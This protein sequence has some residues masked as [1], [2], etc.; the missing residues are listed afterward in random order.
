MRGVEVRRSKLVLG[1]RGSGSVGKG[2]PREENASPGRLRGS[3]G[4]RCRCRG[5]ISVHPGADVHPGPG[6]GA[7]DCCCLQGLGTKWHHLN[8]NPFS[9]RWTA[10]PDKEH[11]SR[12][13]QVTVIK[14]SNICSTSPYTDPDPE[15]RIFRFPWTTDR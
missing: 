13:M 3:T 15:I 2:V 11:F 6:P 10:E 14:I 4:N 7:E 5:N 1:C 8:I 9:E 12:R